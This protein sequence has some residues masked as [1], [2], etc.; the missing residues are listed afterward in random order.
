MS[1]K[2]YFGSEFISFLT[3]AALAAS[4]P[5]GTFVDSTRLTCLRCCNNFLCLRPF[6]VEATLQS[7]EFLAPLVS[8][9]SSVHEGVRSEWVLLLRNMAAAVH[10]CRPDG[11]EAQAHYIAAQALPILRSSSGEVQ[12]NAALALGTCLHTLKH[13]TTRTNESATFANDAKAVLLDIKSTLSSTD[14][15]HLVALEALEF[16]QA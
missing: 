13:S 8:S 7:Q 9:T 1:R 4:A 2:H 5:D 12:W 11:F 15:L 16:L 6:Q 3:A 14:P 10:S